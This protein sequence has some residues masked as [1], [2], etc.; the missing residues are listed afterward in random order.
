MIK[1]RALQED[2]RVAVIAPA[3]PADEEKLKQGIVVLENMGLKVIIGRHVLDVEDRLAVDDE[4]RLAD[5]HEAFFDPTIHGIF[6]AT[7]G[8]GTARIAPMI[9]YARINRNPKIF[10]GYS[11]I[12]YLLNAIQKY[13]DLVTFHGPMVA[14]DLNDEVRS[15]ETESSFSS[16]FTGEPMTYN[17]YKS[18]LIPIAHGTGEGRLVG[19][20]LELLTKGLGT[21]FQINTKGAIL[22]IEEVAAPSFLINAMLTHLKQ[23]GVLDEVKGVVIGELQAD[24]E[25][26]KKIELVLED[27]FACASYPVV[28][29]FHIGHC[30]PN[31]GVPLGTNA[32]LTTAPP[33][34][35]IESGVK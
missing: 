15:A 13:S 32:K 28:R 4:K 22:L 6:C 18:P 23:A 29:G 10:W 1:P 27:F 14:T 17:S 9:D 34:L 12:T 3:G 33:Q 19:G 30:Q 20:N 21:P 7:G 11:D 35:L 25:E 26:S 8:F 5:L 31:Y 2:D 16:L 24:A